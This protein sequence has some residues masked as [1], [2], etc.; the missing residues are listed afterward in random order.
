MD[1]HTIT[2]NRVWKDLQR[3]PRGEKLRFEENGATLSMW[4]EERDAH[5]A[6]AAADSAKQR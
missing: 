6:A 5:E 3:L 1:G 4:I 2:L